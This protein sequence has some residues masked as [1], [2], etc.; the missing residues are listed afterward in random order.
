MDRRQ[1]VALLLA[2]V[3]AHIEW[4]EPPTAF[5]A[6]VVG[7]LEGIP[8]PRAPLF[9]RFVPVAGTLA[10]LVAVLLTFSPAT[11]DAVADFLGIGGVRIERVA[12]DDLPTP[13]IGEGFDFGEPVTLEEAESRV[14][15]DVLE[16][17]L[18]ALGTPDQVYLSPRRPLGGLVALVYGARPGFEVEPVSDVSVLITEFDASLETG[19][20]VKKLAGPDTTIRRVEVNGTEGYWLSGDAHSFF[21]RDADG[22]VVQE[23]LRLVANVLL[24]EQDGVTFR[25]ETTGTLRGARDIAASLR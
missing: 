16:P 18:P 2:D 8:A 3:G 7:K 1:D 19:G 12:P 10:A 13:R 11:R 5:A 25:V 23:S 6:R 22:N 14:A 20:F 15:F 17:T 4:P 9:R 24:W 21:Y